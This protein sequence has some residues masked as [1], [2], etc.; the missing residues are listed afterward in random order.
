MILR[1]IC[2][3]CGKTKF[4]FGDNVCGVCEDKMNDTV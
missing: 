4:L 2:T 3:M 1:Q